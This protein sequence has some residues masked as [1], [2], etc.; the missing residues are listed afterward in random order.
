MTKTGKE[1]FPI[2]KTG[3]GVYS[4]TK[5]GQEFFPITKMGKWVS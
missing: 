1:F 2:I 5:T 4:M 3:K